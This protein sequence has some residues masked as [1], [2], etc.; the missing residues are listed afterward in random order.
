MTTENAS[1]RIVR[2]VNMS[3]PCR[4]SNEDYAL[5]IFDC[6]DHRR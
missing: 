2:Q 1:G 3:L 6:R 5:E 4:T